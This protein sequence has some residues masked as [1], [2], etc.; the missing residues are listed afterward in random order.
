MPERALW[1]VA[2]VLHSSQRSVLWLATV[3]VL[4]MR[5]VGGRVLVFISEFP[6]LGG[7]LGPP[8]VVVILPFCQGEFHRTG[9]G[10]PHDV[11]M[12]SLAFCVFL[13]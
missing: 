3:I 4:L 5:L 10:S 12:A 9:G 6:P 1:W 11:D 7:G 13:S 8:R 2:M